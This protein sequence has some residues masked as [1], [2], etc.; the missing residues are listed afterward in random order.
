MIDGKD[1]GKDITVRHLV[2]QT[3]GLADYEMDFKGEDSIV[4]RL[5]KED[6]ELIED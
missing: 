2:N 4:E 6:F 1:Y 5:R 3:S